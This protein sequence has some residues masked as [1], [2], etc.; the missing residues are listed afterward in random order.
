MGSHSSAGFSTTYSCRRLTFLENLMP[1]A[2]NVPEILAFKHSVAENAAKNSPKK[3]K[4]KKIKHPSMF[5]FFTILPKFHL[6]GRG[7]Q[8]LPGAI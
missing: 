6:D 1:L 2:L 4:S 8:W 3:T 7:P 5:Y